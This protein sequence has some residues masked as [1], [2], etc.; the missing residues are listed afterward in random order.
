MTQQIDTFRIDCT[1][2]RAWVFIKR[3]PKTEGRRPKIENEDE[4]ACN[5]NSIQ[6]RFQHPMRIELSM[7]SCF[8]NKRKSSKL[9][10]KVFGRRFGE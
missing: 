3:G 1:P 6:S 7:A 10:A 9:S 2:L 4:D 8:M 5:K